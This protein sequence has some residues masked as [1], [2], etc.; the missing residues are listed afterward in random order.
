LEPSG[1]AYT[2]DGN[3]VSVTG[4]PA[5]LVALIAI[6]GTDALEG[7]D[8]VNCCSSPGFVPTVQCVVA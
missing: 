5:M 2:F 3:G 1:P 6:D 7:I 8:A 4:G